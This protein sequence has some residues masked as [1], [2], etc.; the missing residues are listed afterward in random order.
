MRE[1]SKRG[2]QNQRFQ[3]INIEDYF[4]LVRYICN[5][6]YGDQDDLFQIGCIAL[7]KAKAKYNPKLGKFTTLAFK[8][9]KNDIIKYLKKENKYKQRIENINLNSVEP[10]YYE[11]FDNY[12]PSLSLSEEIMINMRRD[13]FTIKEIAKKL[14]I[15]N[16]QAEVLNQKTKKKIADA[17]KNTLS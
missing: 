5:K 7:L 2:V 6:F 13:G 16:T 9:V 17:N 1:Q 15:D 3:Q 10:E 11:N 12:I 14:N 4:G 8:C